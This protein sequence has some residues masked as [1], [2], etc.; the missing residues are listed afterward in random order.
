MAALGGIAGSENR[1]ISFFQRTKALLAEAEQ[2]ISIFPSIEN[3]DEIE[4]L[5]ERLSEAGET[6]FILKERAAELTSADRDLEMG[7]FYSNMDQ[8]SLYLTRL[9]VYFE[10]I[11]D[12]LSESTLNVPAHQ[13]ERNYTGTRGQPKFKVSKR[14]IQ[15]LRELHFPWVRI[16][17]LLG[18]STK[19]LTRRRQEFQIEDEGEVNWSSL[20]NG[21]LREIMQE[22]MTVTPRDWSN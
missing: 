7:N 3:I 19:T 10:N 14:Q 11:A 16:A 8:L 20:R 6:V 15:F 1:L 5:H 4:M 18:I 21:E 2:Y 13:C 12:D 22:I 17:E 9:R